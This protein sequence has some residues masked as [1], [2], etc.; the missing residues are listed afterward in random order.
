MYPTGSFVR[1]NINRRFDSNDNLCNCNNAPID[2]ACLHFLMGDILLQ[3]TA[4]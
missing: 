3:R 1:G 2:K 4:R